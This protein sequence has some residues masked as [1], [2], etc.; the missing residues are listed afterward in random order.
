MFRDKPRLKSSSISSRL[1]ESRK[2]QLSRCP[3][4]AHS[5]GFFFRASLP[6]IPK[7]RC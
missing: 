7:L 6:P 4:E 2:T 1:P 5:E 3:V